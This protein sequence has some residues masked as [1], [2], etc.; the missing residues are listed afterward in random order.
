MDER[1]LGEFMGRVEATQVQIL[2]K[3]NEGS[4]KFTAQDERIR[5][6]ETRVGALW[7]LGPLLVGAAA[8]GADVKR[9]IFGH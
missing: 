9:L 2:A 4:A 5:R 3:L 6:L 7:I 8:F 1:E